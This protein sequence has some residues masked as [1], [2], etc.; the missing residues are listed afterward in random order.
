MNNLSCAA[1][2]L[3][4]ASLVFLV[5]RV[6]LL[7]LKANNQQIANEAVAA[8]SELEKAD[9]DV[10][11]LQNKLEEQRARFSGQHSDLAVEGAASS[12]IPIEPD[13][14]GLWPTDR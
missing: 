3:A 8:R 14:D 12:A 1:V 7:D 6:S 5:Q 10:K 13:K 2:I 9:A 4:S 11:D